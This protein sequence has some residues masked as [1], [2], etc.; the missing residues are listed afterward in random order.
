M[1]YK[2]THTWKEINET[3]KVF[4]KLFSENEEYM[5]EIVSA[6]KRCEAKNFVVVARGSSNNALV[7][8]KYFM[9]VMSD[10]TVGLSAPSIVT[11]YRGKINYSNSIII[12]CSSSGMAEDVIEVV[13]RGNEQGAMTI[14]IT[15]D[16]NS[17]LAKESKYNL[18][19]NAGEKKSVVATKSFNAELFLLAWLGSEIAGLKE[20]VFNLKRLNFDLDHVMPYIDDV[21]SKFA[22]KFKDM[23]D[24]FVL[25]RGL[26][27]PIALEGALM[28]QETCYIPV[29][30]YAG[31]DFYHG[32]LA[33]VNKD[34]P[35]IL[36][37]AKYD[38]DEEIQSI[39]R[40]DQ[41][42]CIQKMLSLKAPVLLVTNDSMLVGR[43]KKC[44]DVFLNFNVSEE[45][46]VFAFSVFAQMF[47]CKLSCII[48]NNPDN[49]RSLEKNVVTK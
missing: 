32:P 44:N 30:G 33:M 37:C 17:I 6:I 28:L 34:T 46:A 47:A 15:N 24:G 16:E 36:Y 9:E 21:T 49:P 42:Q 23:K 38:G 12:G 22:E 29:K 7:Y 31:S 20:N 2:D 11:L 4:S 8:F 27:Y 26:S 48:G 25:A 19:L 35:V 43:F 14:G 1:D 39:I 40:A 45:F 13:K 5:K 3:P 41:I 18:F 10:Y